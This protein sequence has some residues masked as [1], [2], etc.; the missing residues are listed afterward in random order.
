L[1]KLQKYLKLQKFQK[2]SPRQQ[3]TASNRKTLVVGFLFYVKKLKTI[4]LSFS[5]AEKQ[6]TIREL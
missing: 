4:G 1:Q 5:L 6:P 3:A 2:T